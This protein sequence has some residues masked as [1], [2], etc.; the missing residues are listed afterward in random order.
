MQQWIF[1]YTYLFKFLLSAFPHRYQKKWNMELLT[2][3]GCCI[4]KFL[5]NWFPQWLHWFTLLSAIQ[6]FSYFFTSYTPTL[7]IFYCGFICIFLLTNNVENMFMNL[8]ALGISSLEKFLWNPLPMFEL[9]CLFCC[10]CRGMLEVI[11]HILKSNL[12]SDNMIC[13]S[14]PFSWSSFCFLDSNFWCTKVKTQFINFFFCLI[15]ESC[16][17]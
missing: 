7:A 14:L 10:C 5:G 15:H 3:M 2:H 6:K 1:V 12:L 8:L 17:H 9:G 4:F 11:L 16:P 13:N